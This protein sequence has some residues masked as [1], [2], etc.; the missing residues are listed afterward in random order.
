V[1]RLQ[2]TRDKLCG[3]ESWVAVGGSLSPTICLQGHERLPQPAACLHR[4]LD[5]A[6]AAG[7]IPTD[8]GEAVARD[9]L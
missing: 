1:L 3:R 2:S 4:E 7:A 9:L 6:L 5:E 8:P